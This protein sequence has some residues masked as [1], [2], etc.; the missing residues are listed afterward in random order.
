MYP[1]FKDIE[2]E[3][4]YEG[5]IRMTRSQKDPYRKAL[6]YLLGLT[7][8][9][10]QHI[11][12]VYDYEESCIRLE[13]LAQGWQTSTSSRLT[14][15]AFNLYSGYA[16]EG[17]RSDHHY[18]PYYIFDNELMLFFFEAVKLRYSEYNRNFV[19]NSRFSDAL[20]TEE[21]HYLEMER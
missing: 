5:N 2:H 14:R 7:P 3:Q 16:G 21:E 10:R 6:F 13:G 4:F 20:I 15:L 11:R 19:P 12:D 8:Q 18:S 17:D 9:T 1:T